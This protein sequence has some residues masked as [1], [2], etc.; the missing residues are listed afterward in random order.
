MDI[1]KVNASKNW[2]TFVLARG[3]DEKR[4]RETIDSKL[5]GQIKQFS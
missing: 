4:D 3:N 1:L 2:A 5:K